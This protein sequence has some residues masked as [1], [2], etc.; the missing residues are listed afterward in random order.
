M[1]VRIGIAIGGLVLALLLVIAF[2]TLWLE[3]RQLRVAPAKVPDIDAPAAAR[4]LAKALRFQ[5][6]SYGPEARVEA[7]A[8]LGL[9]AHLATSYPKIHATLEREV[10]SDYSLLYRWQG[11]DPS[12]KP[13]LLNAHMD[14]VPVEPGTEARWTHPPFSGAIA[15]GFIWGRGTLDMKVSLTGI[16]EA[17]EH[18]LAQDFTPARTVYLAF[19]HDEEA[20]GSRGTAMIARLLEERDIRLLF[21]LDEG[22]AITHGIVPGVEKPAALVGLAE[23]GQVSLEL[24]AHAKGG[25]S[26]M[27][28][29]STAAG[30]LG[31]ALY[32]LETNQ[33]PSRLESPT[34]DMFAY[35]A[36]EMPFARRI[37][38]A[39]LWL[40][41]PWLISR[42]EDT[43]AVNALIRT[44]TAPTIIQ[45]GV[46]SNVL[47]SEAR[48]VVNFRILPGDTVASV[49]EHV[50][51]TIDDQDVTVRRVGN[52]PS[53]PTPVSDSQAESFTALRKTIHQVFPDVV[54]APGL[55]IGRTDS[56]RYVKVAENS[57]RFLP[58]RLGREDLKRIHG[59]DE[60]ISVNNYLE[61]V[62]FYIQLLRNIDTVG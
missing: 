57:Y 55:V 5:T 33:M 7:E 22:M 41:E 3:S 34:V 52:E 54:V 48:A 4:R 28:P 12:L 26:S 45:G 1:F 35:L 32:R 46:K 15:D 60:R 23:K 30:K 10:L 29:V 51:A 16:L 53:D 39:N 2:N 42:L 24:T 43:P 27:P 38:L 31:R 21:T 49:I 25:H 14:V 13:I 6:I 58:M 56:R 40:F 8:F 59:T 17:I 20:G 62:R 47:P 18:L 19:S 50:H 44:T 61:I 9:H 11:S 36:P 37:A